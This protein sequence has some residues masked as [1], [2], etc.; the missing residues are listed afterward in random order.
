MSLSI[1]VIAS[2]LQVTLNDPN[3]RAMTL[4]SVDSP[5]LVAAYM[6]SPIGSRLAAMDPMLMIRPHL[7]FR[8]NFAA[9]REMRNGAR[10]LT[11]TIA[12]AAAGGM[13]MAY[14][15]VSTAALLTTMSM[16]GTSVFNVANAVAIA[17]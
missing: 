5:A 17:A 2:V 14:C 1:A 9:S 7:L 13:I 3:S 4:A 10:R 6:E 15:D 8:I 11:F 16:V 12:C